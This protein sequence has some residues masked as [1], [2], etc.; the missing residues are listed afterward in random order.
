MTA[1]PIKSA[2]FSCSL[3]ALATSASAQ[4]MCAGLGSAGVWI[5]G[6]EGS[7]DISTADNYREQ[8]ALVLGGTEYVSLFSLSQPS[9]VRIEAQGRGSGDPIIEVL[10]QNGALV[11]SDDDSGGNGASRAEVT[12]DPGTYCVSTTS[13]DASPMTAFVRIGRDEQEPLTPGVAATSTD[14]GSGSDASGCSDAQSLGV[15]TG[16]LESELSVNQAPFLRF[17]LDAPLAL[18]LTAENEDA[19][20][21]LTLYDGSENYIDEND[22]ADGLNS[23]L[24]VTETLP[25]GD[26]CIGIDAL[27]DADLPILVT[28]SE[29]DPA[30]ALMAMVDRAEAAPPLDGTVEIIDLGDLATRVRRDAQVTDQATW[31]SV[32]LPEGGLL[33]IEAISADGSGDPLLA[34]F[35]DFG[36]EVAFNDDF[37]DGFDAQVAARVSSGTYYVGLKEV[38][39]DTQSF[40][41]MGL[42]RWVPAK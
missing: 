27:N 9:N 2:A 19:D 22:D 36:R 38:A 3:L 15:L 23:R 35:D 25:A 5:G 6:S 28:V 14:V 8:M 37:G 12:L 33:L 34:L 29:Y 10:D 26:Y 16:T 41:R 31:F 4:D 18:S 32:N 17:T 24:D 20:P 42:E 7:S 30:A 40:I 1:F 39:A 21:V 11:I 13:Y